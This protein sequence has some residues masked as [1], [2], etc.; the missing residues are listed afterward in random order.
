M[1]GIVRKRDG[2]FQIIKVM[3][4]KYKKINIKKP[5]NQKFAAKIMKKNE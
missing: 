2:T 1:Q 4:T 5:Y 3:A